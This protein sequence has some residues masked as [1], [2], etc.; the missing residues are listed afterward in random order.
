[1]LDESGSVYIAGRALPANNF[2]PLTPGAF[3]GVGTGFASKLSADGSRLLYSTR[4]P[5]AA[6]QITVI[7]EDHLLVSGATSTDFYDQ[8][9]TTPDSPSP[10]S[11]V[12]VHQYLLELNSA[13]T[14]RIYGTYLNSAVTTDGIH[15]WSVSQDP[16][17]IL[18]RT[19]VH[20]SL[21]PSIT[22]VANSATFYS[23]AVAPGELISIFGPGIGPDQ[24]ASLQL[25][26]S[27]KVGTE[28]GGMKVYINGVAAPLTY[29]SINQINA[30]VPFEVAVWA[31]TYVTVLKNGAVLPEIKIPVASASP[32]FFK[33][34]WG[35]TVIVNQSGTVNSPSSPAPVGSIV[36]LY[37]TGAG[38]MRTPIAT[39][40]VGD[41][42]TLPVLA[43]SA[44]L[45]P[46]DSGQ[47]FFGMG[48]CPIAV[49]YFGD[50]PTLVQGVV[51]LNL[52]IS[53]FS[54]VP[55]QDT[56]LTISFGG[57]RPNQVIQVW[58]K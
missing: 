24:P 1:V 15:V 35:A 7:A 6:T 46:C 23:G 9:P 56:F 22:C 18:D 11:D 52:Q 44:A 25:D 28:L 48:S 14:G 19:L 53:N 31:D 21:E 16:N 58:V 38:L 57:Y 42:T 33:W 32:G 49:N 13:A 2:F 47:G 45:G 40:S 55:N 20:P 36:T 41:G 10:C 5:G 50:A 26:A 27:G 4:L 39:G 34:P 37:G 3:M 12:G 43:A 8:V 29:V 54:S 30:V 17:K 51:A